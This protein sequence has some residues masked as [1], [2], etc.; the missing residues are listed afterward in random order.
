MGD[1]AGSSSRVSSSG[2]GHQET[3]SDS[4]GSH[5]GVVVAVM[6]V[7]LAVKVVMEMMVMDDHGGR[8]VKFAMKMP[9]VLMGRTPK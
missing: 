1:S 6:K 2:A 4:K 9:V 8:R 7:T 5:R 3:G